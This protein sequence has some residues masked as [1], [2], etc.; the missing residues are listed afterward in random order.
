MYKAVYM[1][2]YK[3]GPIHRWTPRLPCCSPPYVYTHI[4][5]VVIVLHTCQVSDI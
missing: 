4:S 2:V 3:G 5:L 1:S